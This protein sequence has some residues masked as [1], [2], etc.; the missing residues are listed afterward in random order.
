MHDAAAMA[1][2]AWVASGKRR[3]KW[4]HLLFFRFLR[5]KGS[6][7]CWGKGRDKTQANV[8]WRV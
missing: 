4:R 3:R 5:E 8:N 1:V 2:A 6:S 7:R